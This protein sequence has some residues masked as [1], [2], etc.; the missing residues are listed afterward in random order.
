MEVR[1]MNSLWPNPFTD[2]TLDNVIIVW[3]FLVSSS[4]SVLM[5]QNVLNLQVLVQL[6]VLFHILILIEI[7]YIWQLIHLV[8]SGWA[9]VEA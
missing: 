1:M 4:Q 2:P 9:V 6:I 3:S 7:G 8:V 5:C